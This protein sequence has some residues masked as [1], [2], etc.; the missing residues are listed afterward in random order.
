MNT[1]FNDG[2]SKNIFPLPSLCHS[3]GE[4]LP[5]PSP[6]PKKMYILAGVAFTWYQAKD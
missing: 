2:L 3:A 5:Q 1:S 4:P 6:P